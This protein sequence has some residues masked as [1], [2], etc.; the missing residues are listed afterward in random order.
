LAPLVSK[1]L[2]PLF[3]LGLFNLFKSYAPK[4][5]D[6]WQLAIG[7]PRGFAKTFFIKLLICYLVIFT[8]R[9]F[10]LVVAENLEKAASIISDVFTMLSEPMAITAFGDPRKKVFTANNKVKKFQY[11]DKVVIL[12]AIG[13][14]GGIR[15]IVEDNA[16]PDAMFF[17]DIQSSADAKSKEISLALEQELYGTAMKAKD[18][19]GCIFV[20]VANMY[21]T[22]WSLLRRMKENPNWV[23]IITGGILADGTSLWEDLQPITQ[24]KKEFMNDYLSG[25]AEVF[26]AEVMNDEKAKV[27]NKFSLSN[28]P[29]FPFAPDDIPSARAI[30][31]DPSGDTPTSD[32]VTITAF[33]YY[34]GIPVAMEILE[35]KFSPGETVENALKLAIKWEA[36][37]I[38]YESVAYQASLL[39]WHN[40]VAKLNMIVGIDAYPIP[41]GRMSKNSKIT[42]ML[43]A[44]LV[45]EIFCHPSQID[46]LHR[47]IIDFDPNKTD[48]VDGILDTMTFGQYMQINYPDQIVNRR[49]FSLDDDSTS[50]LVL[51]NSAF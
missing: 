21:P 25:N 2:F 44:Y 43:K 48:N 40:Y 4:T 12:K 16:R 27:L 6:F 17:D 14:D 10:I 51:Y 42:A 32:A 13:I 39:Y 8:K 31:V 37:C 30:V 24:L 41:S 20:F 5:R 15:G 50:A 46:L 3:Y 11:G 19:A 45:G 28:L 1:F 33:N 35:G 23:K 36:A 22:K 38:G 18:P 49:A 29:E 9:R 26:Y 34:A 47:Q 7:L